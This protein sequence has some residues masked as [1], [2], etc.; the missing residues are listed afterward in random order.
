MSR[1]SKLCRW[2]KRLGKMIG[3]FTMRD[4]LDGEIVR[5]LA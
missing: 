3:A 4:I 2:F 5:K 1:P